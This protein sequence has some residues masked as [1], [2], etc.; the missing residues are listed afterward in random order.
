MGRAPVG[1]R[2]GS[3]P[4][5]HFSSMPTNHGTFVGGTFHTSFNGHGGSF[6]PHHVGF[7][8]HG[9]ARYRFYYRWPYGYYGYSP[10]YYSYY[11]DT[12]NTSDESYG[13]QNSQLQQELSQLSDEVRR[14]REESAERSVEPAPPQY[15][16]QPQSNA[17]PPTPTTLVLRNGRTQKVDNYAIAGGTIWV[18]TNQRARKIPL[19]EV[20]LSATQKVNE[21][22]GVPFRVP[23]NR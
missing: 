14:L 5:P 21:E 7:H 20:D 19:S 16:P 4:Q 22:Q 18:F 3:M 23:G 6:H 1:Q 11:P 15:S 12:Y 10:G 9:N 8:H 17:P 2:G 13:E